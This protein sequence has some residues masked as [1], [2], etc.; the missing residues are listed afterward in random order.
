MSLSDLLARV[1]PLLDDIDVQAP[2][3]TLFFSVSDG[4]Q[5]AHVQIARGGDLERAW[6]AGAARLRRWQRQSGVRPSWLRVDRV[7]Q[8]RQWSWAQL[9]ACL[10]DTKRNYL[11]YGLAL[12]EDFSIA[13]L[14]EELGANALLYDN[15]CEHAVANDANLASYGKR[16]F[17]QALCWPK[18]DEPIWTFT[19]RAVF[20]DTRCAHLIE[21]QGPHAGYRQVPDWGERPVRAL[22]DSAT[23]YLAR[24]VTASGAYDY[25]WFP[26]F[27][28][29]IPTYN[30]LRH[31]SSTYA[32][33]EG[34]ELERLPGQLQ[35]IERALGYLQRR[36]IHPHVL[37]D[38][39][40]AAFLRDTGNEIKLGGNAVS[41]L[42][43]VKYTELTG[44]RRY[45]PLM[46]ALAR[47]I[48]FMQ[49]PDSG[50]FVHV[51]DCPG[52]SLKEETRIV[53]Y[54]GEA[55][56]ALVRLYGLSRD[57]R[58][59][60][61]VERAFEHFIEA[62]HWQAH[63]HWLGYCVN[64]L[65]RYRP[66]ERYYRFGLDNVR[67]H[68]GF[69]LERIT[70]YPTLLELM[71][72][73]RSMIERIQ[74]DPGMVHLLDDFD[75][76]AFQRALEHRARYLLNGFFWPEL[77]MFFKN[78]G[79]IVGS[80]F[81][82]HHSYRVRIDDV[83]HYLSGYVAYW[84]Y[85]GEAAAGTPPGTPG[86]ALPDPAGDGPPVNGRD[87]HCYFCNEDFGK[88]LTG[89]ERSA[90]KRANLF[91]EHLGIVPRVLSLKLNLSVME[92]WRHYQRI[93]WV[94]ERVALLNLYE[95]ILRI[96]EG[97]R[98][99]PAALPWQ[100]GWTQQALAQSGH[101]RVHDEHGRLVMYV[102][103]RDESLERLAYINHFA[104]GRKIRRDHFNRFGQLALSQQLD[105]QGRVVREDGFTPRGRM[106]LIRLWQAQTGTLD[107]ILLLNRDGL[108]DTCFDSEPALA[109]WWL[110]RWISTEGNAFLIDKHRAWFRPLCELKRHRRQRLVSIIHSCHV[111]AEQD[112]LL[113]GRLN[114][115]YRAALSG[116]D[117]DACVVLTPQQRDDVR[118]RFPQAP[119][120]LRAIPHTGER[121]ARV[122]FQ[123]RD[124]DLLVAFV[125]LAAEKRIED[126]LQIMARLLQ[127][128]PRKRLHI[129]GE[130]SLRQAI[131]AGIDEL[132][133]QGRV[134][135]MGYV[136][137][138][139][140][141]LDRASFSLL[142]SRREAFPL[143]V[144]ES[145]GHGCPVL[146]YDIPYGPASLI[147]H[148]RNGL[149]I[150]DGDIQGAVDAL[151]RVFAG[152]GL[153]RA[154]SDGAYSMS[155]E[156]LV[157]DV[158]RMWSALLH[159][160]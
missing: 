107:R 110:Q 116:R 140:E 60:A 1:R 9:D 154:L 105:E 2:H 15:R 134:R 29:P 90:L 37:E 101:Q 123:S 34:W 64:E 48:L 97:E 33:L 28:R 23:D 80:C 51:L 128:H 63:D 106:R 129:Y 151:D 95:D 77:A 131:E 86:T 94:N 120:A 14:E 69:V 21:H 83:E 153:L 126:M 74:G 152:Q 30:A 12:A 93:G 52:L 38:G 22:I 142:T 88:R 5:R 3:C 65:T 54:D 115:H 157:Q 141:V 111:A 57:E 87:R 39:S 100:P 155:A 132:G 49:K 136:E 41:I 19:T 143:A 113:T 89:I 42:A 40:Q 125:R 13:M 53:Y 149:L 160:E 156:V 27:D 92:N 36:L 72:A 7:D 135:L 99:P 75:L 130:G 150:A 84:K 118:R 96:A 25:G 145:L 82:R 81:I 58:W 61:A 62:R 103:W 127:R 78:P 31:A 18:G 35:A 104:N 119:Y 114:G 6:R 44:D 158:A 98:L 117:V 76:E 46:E 109:G 137:N 24:Q 138:V 108:P 68:L 20:S 32:L 159:E 59:L 102:V 146:A 133:L 45:L 26:C 85:L 79:R 71:M 73:A 47:G 139:G 148:G 122:D 56:F 11:K 16:R 91:V 121:V 66:Q 70:T 43:L 50:A 112:D 4:S 124:P 55:A 10:R 67:D 144:Q 147:E 17:G 8:V